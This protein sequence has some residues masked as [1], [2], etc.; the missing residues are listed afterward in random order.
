MLFKRELRVLDYFARIIIERPN[1]VVNLPEPVCF[2]DPRAC[3][4]L[5]G[6]KSNRYENTN[7]NDSR[8]TLDF[9][10]H[11]RPIP[12]A[13]GYFEHFVH[14][15]YF[16]LQAEITAFTEHNGVTLD[17]RDDGNSP[18]IR[19]ERETNKMAFHTRSVS[20]ARFRRGLIAITWLVVEGS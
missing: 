11:P 20:R 19:P 3:L 6:G 1:I 8:E 7:I 4:L 5:P 2:R 9:F 10:F 18:M 14:N 12:L 15:K 16:A 13:T 17:T